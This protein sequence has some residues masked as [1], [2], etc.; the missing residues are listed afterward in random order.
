[1]VKR[2]LFDTR[3]ACLGK[4]FGWGYLSF[5]F[6]VFALSGLD[7]LC[8]ALFD[9]EQCSIWNSRQKELISEATTIM[10]YREFLFLA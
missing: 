1:M 6:F 2:S 4:T 8:L 9:D 10:N 3:H 7:C 5:L